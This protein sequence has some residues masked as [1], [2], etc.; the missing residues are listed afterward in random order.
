MGLILVP[1]TIAAFVVATSVAISLPLKGAI[2]RL[3]ATLLGVQAVITLTLLGAGV[4]VR[5]LDVAW[6]LFTL[7]VVS[8]AGVA[9]SWRLA[10]R[11]G[12]GVR[13][14]AWRSDLVSAWRAASAS[15][16]VIG[17][18]ILTALALAW[19]FA[20]AV[21]LPILDYD[22]LS[23]HVVTVD[24]WLQ[25]NAIG[26]IP[27]RIWS[28]GYPANS[29]LLTLWLMAFSR[30]DDL[31]PL[32]GL[33]PLPLA[34]LAVAGLAR[35]LGAARIWAAAVGMLFV[36]LP[37]VIILADTTYVDNLAAADLAAAWFLGLSA[38][39][40]PAGRRRTALLVATGLAIGF[41]AGTKASTLFPLG[42]FGAALVLAEL[43]RHRR[44]AEAFRSSLATA[45]LVGVPTLLG[46]YWYLKNLVVFGN[47]LWPFTFGP[48]QG[49]GT[50]QALIR[51]QPPQLAG[52][53]PARQVLF[54]W[55][56]DFHLTSYVYDSRL[57]GFG[58]AWLAVVAAAI[59]GV[60]FLARS[61]AWFPIMAMV[62][63]TAA[64]LAVMPFQWWPRYT[65]FVPI[66]ALALTALTLTRV[67]R[68]AAIPIAAVIVAGSLLSLGVATRRANVQASTTD[69]RP[70]V[71]HLVRLVVS[72]PGTR[73][74][75]G[76]WA[77]CNLLG[78]IPPG[79]TVA[80]D[81]FSLVH[82]L[83]GHDLDR[84]LAPPVGVTGDPAVLRQ[85]AASVGAGYLALLE[86]PSIAAARADPA[87][88][89]DLGP[90][91][92]GVE[93]VRMGSG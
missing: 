50:V 7:A 60:A 9:M 75:L 40:A 72:G 15:R 88:F 13:L 59:V 39:R 25:T 27:Q 83:V 69:V 8:A 42:V 49:V 30:S 45:L 52:M 48:W 70:S 20:L 3:V 31:A 57:G 91:C 51:Q 66:I 80:T 77:K 79:S 22:G 56:Y 35:R 16:L 87:T 11:D 43:T 38:L 1:A 34:G 29:E 76:V 86:A 28:D 41:S 2:E 36:L 81:G 14:A 26:R 65:L 63:P 5:R 54:S 47:P 37:A 67:P 58:V 53:S 78:T 71:T 17:L 89:T 90:V 93:L 24:V 21:R 6:I 18:G 46:G 73:A 44:L 82:L 19:R 10:R 62:V 12:F 55:L 4:L 92:L 61:R 74:E 32:T 23:Y 68:R 64:N 33:L 85:E 84:I